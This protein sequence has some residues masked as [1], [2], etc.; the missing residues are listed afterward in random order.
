MHKLTIA[1]FVLVFVTG[2]LTT[3]AAAQDAGVS[4]EDSGLVI[5]IEEPPDPALAYENFAR[6]EIERD[7]RRSRIALI[8]TSAAVVVGAAVFYPLVLNCIEYF[9]TEGAPPRCGRGAE[10]GATTAGVV[11]SAGVVGMVVTGIMLGV[12]KSKLRRLDDTRAVSFDP[13]RGTFVF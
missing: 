13:D 6:L 10:A 9:P 8:S 3:C 7:I 12:R 11:M 1:F 2:A 5:W 4:Q